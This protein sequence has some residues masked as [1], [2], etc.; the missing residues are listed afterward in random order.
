MAHATPID[1]NEKNH[2]LINV[3]NGDKIKITF[4]YYQGESVPIT[5]RNGTS[6]PKQMY[7]WRYDIE[8]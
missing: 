3:E 2:T 1:K 6:W 7:H 5:F 8:R 4:T